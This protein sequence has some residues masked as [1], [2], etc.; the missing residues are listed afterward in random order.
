M[1]ANKDESMDITFIN[2]KRQKFSLNLR[3]DEG[4]EL[5]FLRH[6]FYFL[7]FY[8]KDSVKNCKKWNAYQSN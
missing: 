6:T 2:C 8:F 4:K 7:F 3:Q 1:K 5:F